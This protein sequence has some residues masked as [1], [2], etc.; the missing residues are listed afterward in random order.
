MLILD[1][2][3]FPKQNIESVGMARQYCGQM[4][5]T[6]TCQAGM[7]LAYASHLGYALL[8]RTSLM[9][10]ASIWAKAP[11]IEPRPLESSRQPRAIS[12]KPATSILCGHYCDHLC[13]AMDYAYTSVVGDRRTASA[14]IVLRS[15]DW[16]FHPMPLQFLSTMRWSLLPFVILKTV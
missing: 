10:H 16:L 11:L 15:V 2:S 5:K 13:T 8:S 9:W 7:F 14:R 12:D 3:D 1:G 4:G 6:V